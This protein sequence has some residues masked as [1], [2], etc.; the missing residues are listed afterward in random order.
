LDKEGDGKKFN[1][2]VIARGNVCFYRLLSK[3][4]A[5]EFK[6]PKLPPGY[7]ANYILIDRNALPPPAQNN[8]QKPANGTGTGNQ[9]AGKDQR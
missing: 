1:V 6:L 2:S 7:V 9:T 4:G 5:P 3:C 8:S